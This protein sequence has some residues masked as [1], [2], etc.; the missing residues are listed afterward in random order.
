MQ[1]VRVD[2]QQVAQ[3]RGAQMRQPPPCRQGVGAARCAACRDDGLGVGP[4]HRLFADLRRERRKALED[5]APAA[6]PQRFVD[7]MLAIDG[8]QRAVPD[9]IEN[10]HFALAR[11]L[12][13]Q[14]G[15]RGVEAHGARG[16]RGL[17][18]GQPTQ[19]Q[20][21]AGDVAQAA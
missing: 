14:L 1:G 8:E 17:G 9:L 11:L 3:A 18:A 12:R 21:G 16:G 6:Q 5:V 20:Q 15:H 7:E 2:R 19:A 10:P 13:A 4:Q